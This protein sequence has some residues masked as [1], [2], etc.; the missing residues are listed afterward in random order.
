MVI[1]ILKESGDENRVSMLPQ[2]AGTLVKSSNQVIMESGGGLGA[3]KSDES[4]KEAG[5]G[6][7]S[8][9]EIFSSA[10]I[11]LKINP[12]SEKEIAQLKKHTI[13]AG[14][15]QPLNNPAFGST[16][17]QNKIVCFSLDSVPRITRAQSMDVLSSMST[18]AGYKAV[19]MAASRL[20]RFFPML[21]TAAG[22]IAPSKVLILG[23]GVAGLQAIATAR[24]LGAVVEVFDTRFAVKEQVESLGARFVE[25]EGAE[26]DSK[27]GGYAVEQ[28]EAFKQKQKETIHQHIKRSDIVI[29]TALI[30]G[31]KAPLLIPK[32]MVESMKSGSVI[33]DLAAVA[34]GN[35]ELTEVDKVVVHNQVSIIGDSNLP[36]TMAEDASRMYGKNLTNFLKLIIADGKLNINHEDEI[37]K[38]S[39]ITKNSELLQPKAVEEEVST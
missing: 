27:A 26:E 38:A 14:V 5:V 18:I 25:V 7:V 11:I 17:A 21:M 33:V 4:Y 35:C 29:T 37:I 20:P 31:K 36:S 23:A 15:Y 6:I 3:F 34:G 39:C 32:E 24:R 13:L 8:R 12:L 30:P 19:L 1:G 16:L 9:E 10:E 22:T 28:S 2:E